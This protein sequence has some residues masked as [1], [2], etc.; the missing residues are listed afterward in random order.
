[1]LNSIEDGDELIWRLHW[2]RF[3]IGVGEHVPLKVF[4]KLREDHLVPERVWS[5]QSRALNARFD[6]CDVAV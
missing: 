3:A 6:V 2:Q 1:M 5:L 4:R